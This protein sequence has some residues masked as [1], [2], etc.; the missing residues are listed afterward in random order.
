[1]EKGL[2]STI[3][4]FDSLLGAALDSVPMGGSNKGTSA[5]PAETAQSAADLRGFFPGLGKLNTCASS[6]TG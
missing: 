4:N 3:G 2:H 5:A 1:M 6:E